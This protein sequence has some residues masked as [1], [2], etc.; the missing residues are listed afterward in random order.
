MKIRILGHRVRL[1]LTQSEVEKIG[2]NES[3]TE[4]TNFGVG[5]LTYTLETHAEGPSVLTSFEDS[6]IRI[7]VLQTEAKTWA[8]S[9]QVGIQTP[10]DARPFVLIEKDFKCLTVRE[11][12]DESDM[13]LNPNTVC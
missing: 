5:Q 8:D 1:R 2:L 12:E 13:Y 3:V 11:G 10:S 7:S 4:H 9:D 6:T